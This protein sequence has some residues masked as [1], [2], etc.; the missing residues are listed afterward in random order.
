MKV[1]GA[2]PWEAEVDRDVVRRFA[3]DSA[4]VSSE[5]I[6]WVVPMLPPSGPVRVRILGSARFTT[7]TA[8]HERQHADDIRR[9]CE[10]AHGGLWN[11]ALRALAGNWFDSDT[12][13]DR[14]LFQARCPEEF[15][16][17]RLHR[18]ASAI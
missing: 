8:A 14:A 17:D 1:P 15:R 13:L 2:G 18:L 10:S 16:G 3:A 12:A 5:Q 9:A 6:R 4:S 7:S 11:N